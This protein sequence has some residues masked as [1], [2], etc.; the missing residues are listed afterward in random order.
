M[1]QE[2]SY[3]GRE[4][5]SALAVQGTPTRQGDEV[6]RSLRVVCGDCLISVLDG[7]LRPTVEV[8]Q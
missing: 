4:D 6:T 5:A 2:C 1:T 3:C 7:V 8:K